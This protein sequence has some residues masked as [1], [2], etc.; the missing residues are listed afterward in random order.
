MLSPNRFVGNENRGRRRS[1][2][3][4]RRRMRYAVWN[5]RS[6]L[7]T[8]P[9]MTIGCYLRK[10]RRV[11]SLLRNTESTKTL[12]LGIFE[13]AFFGDT[14]FSFP[15]VDHVQNNREYLAEEIAGVLTLQGRTQVEC[16]DC[17]TDSYKTICQLC[18]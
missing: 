16:N 1:P 10:V 15:L 8:Q 14:L 17:V 5:F 12:L 18:S 6:P 11:Q 13:T 7:K 2:Y 9:Y 4:R 3:T